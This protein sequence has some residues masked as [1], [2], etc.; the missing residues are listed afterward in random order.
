MNFLKNDL[1][2]V[3][4]K[5]CSL[6]TLLFVCNQV[7]PAQPPFEISMVSTKENDLFHVLTNDKQFL[8]HRFDEVEEGIRQ[9]AE[10]G[11]LL[12]LADKYPSQP[13]GIQK[14]AWNSINKRKLKV[15]VEYPSFVPGLEIAKTKIR[16]T[17][18][19]AVINS[20]SL[21]TGTGLKYYQILGINDGFLMPINV[22]N[23]LVVVAKVAGL[24]QAV[25]GLEETE[26]HPL[27][28]EHQGALVATSKLSG[29]ATGRYGPNKAWQSLWQYILTKLIGE[30]ITGFDKWPSYVVPSYTKEEVLPADALTTSVKK[31]VEWFWK[32][33]FFVHPVWFDRY[34]TYEGE[35]KTPF[36]PPLD[37]DASNGDGSMGILEGHASH[38]YY[39]GTQKYRYWVRAD[40]QGEAAFALASAAN[41][42]KDSS[43]NGYAERLLDYTYSHSNLRSGVRDQVIDPNY[44]LV[45]WAVTHPH[46]YYT[47]DN[48]RLILGTLGAAAFMGVDRWNNFLVENILANF[49]TSGKEG[50]RGA[51]LEEKQL[52]EKGWKYFFDR[53]LVNPHP[54]HESWMWACYLWLYRQTGYQPLL[55]K[56]KL[57]IKKTMEAY[58]VGWKWTNGIQQERARMILPLAWLVQVEDTPEHRKW[59]DKMVEELLNDQV[60]CGAIAEAI[61]GKG[62]GRYG[63]PR[64]NAAYGETEAPLIFANGEPISDMLYTCNFAY[65]ALHE[66]AEATG[67]IRYRNA[68]DKLGDFLVRIQVR[69]ERYPDLDGAWLR[70]FDFDKWEYWGSNADS[71]WGVWGTLTGWTQS[72]IIATHVLRE[73]KTSLWELTS[74]LDVKKEMEEEVNVM[75]D[76]K[77]Q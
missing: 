52:S 36:G 42:L 73:E 21:T 7:F 50:F 62:K 40:V 6:L 74:S 22:E 59:L 60:N 26:S 28:F 17:I 37:Q 8:I 53:D 46:I 13:I 23:P 2:F 33:H 27:L 34:K 44:G 70:G 56:A 66:A 61:G 4:K 43:K 63:P 1:A 31:G 58:P 51:F 71:G 55:A 65:F 32:G 15:Y 39:N 30:K 41:Y 64:S 68:V 35:G 48:A 38:I 47:D 25:Y 49:R 5:I 10:G 19:R 72:W 76:G 77:L 54:H 11:V 9:T 14:E 75:L 24:D 67:N 29:F 20:K 45:G 69:S 3:M 18:E 16:T 57:A 12:I